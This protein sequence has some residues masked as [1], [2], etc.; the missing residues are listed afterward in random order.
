MDGPVIRAGASSAVDERPAGSSEDHN[1]RS[2]NP[3]DPPVIE[4]L[5]HAAP[6]AVLAGRLD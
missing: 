1:E 3:I 6:S 4:L 2:I 5:G